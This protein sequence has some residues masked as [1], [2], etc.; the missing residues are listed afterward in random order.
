MR[1]FTEVR[2]KYPPGLI[3]AAEFARLIGVAKPNVHRAIKEGRIPVYD[4]AGAPASPNDR[5]RKYLKPEEAA[6]AWRSSRKRLDATSDATLISYR[7]ARETLQ[8]DLLRVKLAR[9]RGE[10]VSK[11]EQIATFE[12][13]G[14]ILAR[15]IQ[16]M[17]DWAEELYAVAKT[18]NIAATS[19]EDKGLLQ[20]ARRPHQGRGRAR[21]G[22]AS[23]EL[24][25]KFSRNL[26]LL[27]KGKEG[28]RA[29]ALAPH[30]KAFSS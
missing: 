24:A 17:P 29:Q 14:R 8:G 7:I 19:G 23:A 27:E 22:H 16:T 10:L 15:E 30:P 3:T 6:I 11:A 21:V 1:H 2:A 28:Q 13:A 4:A 18:G 12:R 20:Q 5:V 26:R 9:E 25:M